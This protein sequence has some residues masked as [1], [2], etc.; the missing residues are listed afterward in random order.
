MA[1]PFV[2]TD[3]NMLTKSIERYFRFVRGE[4]VHS[5]SV[6]SPSG[7]SLQWVSQTFNQI[8]DWLETKDESDTIK[9]CLKE[10][11]V[12]ISLSDE[13]LDSLSDLNP[14]S[15]NDGNW[16][17]VVA[18]LVLAFPEVHWVFI[19]A[20]EAST[21]FL[22]TADRDITN[23]RFQKA[24]LFGVNNTLSDIMNFH[25][26][27]FTPLFDPTGLRH[28]IRAQ[29]NNKGDKQNN[30]FV[31]HIPVRS[32]I[33]AAIDEEDAYTYFNAYIAYRLGYRTHAV[34][35]YGMMG[36]VFKDNGVGSYPTLV[37]EDL[38][39]NFSDRPPKASL[40]D[41][42]VR[43]KLF[44]GIDKAETRIFITSGHEYNADGTTREK[45]ADCL[46]EWQEGAKN[47]RER[48]TKTL[49]KPLSGIFD[50]WKK[51]GLKRL[52]RGN[53]GLAPGY[54]WPPAKREPGEPTGPHSSPGRL[55]EIA[56]RLI[57][58]AERISKD[59]QL[60]PEL[61]HGALLVLDAQEYLDHRTPTT[62]L[63]ALSLKHAL[64]VTAEC[65]FYGIEYNK[66]VRS[67]LAEIEREV[68][69]IG[70]W[71]RRKTRPLSTLDAEIGIVSDLVLRF[72]EYNQFDEEQ[73]CLA[74]VRKLHRQLWV[75]KHRAWAWPFYIF[76]WYVEFLLG[77]MLVF[78]LAIISWL[79]LLSVMFSLFCDC[80]AIPG[81]PPE[82]DL[83][84][85]GIAHAITTFFGL[86]PA[87][88]PAEMERLG[89][90]ASGATMLA[91]SAGFVHLGIFVS[92]LY[93]LIA[94]R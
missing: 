33:A 56:N 43:K 3:S 63:E 17:A 47:G 9:S 54:V 11:V 38:Y 41:L 61:V 64:E 86:Q 81:Q 93:S 5:H 92:H 7:N 4:T 55:L 74:R 66:D 51:S 44:P 70:E 23:P 14:V 45:N 34:C 78:V 83:V 50:L 90:L 1:Q 58:R 89:Y 30:Q 19:T 35:S 46:L 37:F 65:K 60:V 77:S 68:R 10:T 12:F 48:F 40:S 36:E 31:P 24:H 59:A 72:R 42:T 69:S 75:K 26:M 71:F 8:A 79:A 29:I 84:L 20:H 13:Q 32:S 52:L 27:R 91:V 62:S 57:K 16:A 15:T 28:S 53:K 49:Y 82:F 2:I 73:N 85:H 21:S 67:R 76:R 25:E 18:M 6:P 88:S 80:H 87:H 22:R 94:R 39:L